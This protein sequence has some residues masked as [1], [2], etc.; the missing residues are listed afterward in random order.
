VSVYKKLM[1][2]TTS[3]HQALKA[4][5]RLKDDDYTAGI[6]FGTD[7]IKY[8]IEVA[9]AKMQTSLS[10]KP[11]PVSQNFAGMSVELFAE[12]TKSPA[13]V[14]LSRSEPLSYVNLEGL[15]ASVTMKVER[16]K[17]CEFKLTYE[18]I[19]GQLTV[20]DHRLEIVPSTSTGTNVAVSE[21]WKQLPNLPDQNP[22][23]L[24]LQH[25]W[26]VQ[27]AAII[28]LTKDG[29]GQALIEALELPDVLQMFVGVD[30]E[31]PITLGITDV[32]CMLAGSMRLKPAC[33]SP[34]A[35]V[36]ETLN[37]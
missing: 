32:F 29:V 18:T 13:S 23:T 9:I 7:F 10:G 24:E 3:A 26:E 4:F 34:Y 16:T 1:S 28:L 25:E 27:Q 6:A 22:F 12:V 36:R 15:E 2:N 14:T 20:K 19:Q 17:F 37:N 30:F 5:C 31:G 35:N 21:D 11:Y 33:P 8:M